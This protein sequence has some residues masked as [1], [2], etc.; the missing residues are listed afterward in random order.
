MIYFNS[1]C[2]EDEGK[3]TYGQ[4]FRDIKKYYKYAIYSGRAGLKAEVAIPL[5]LALVDFRSS[6][7]YDHIL[8]P[9]A[10]CFWAK[11]KIL[12]GLC[13]YRIKYVGFFLQKS[14]VTN[15]RVV[16]NN[17]SIVTKVYLPKFILVLIEMFKY[18]FRMAIAFWTG[19]R[20]DDIVSCQNHLED[21]VCVPHF[22]C[23]ISACIWNLLYS[24]TFWRIYRGLAKCGGSRDAAFVLYIRSIL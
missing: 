20:D 21:F 13:I 9:V 6:V 8:V 11:N 18:G 5:K 15:V 19:R 3:E 17:S 2:I 14:I 24:S 4:I 7:I 10:D 16:T 1:E 12:Y 23:T 22:L